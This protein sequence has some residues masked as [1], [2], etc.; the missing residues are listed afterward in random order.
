MWSN[1]ELPLVEAVM[2]RVNVS[3]GA[4]AVLKCR[5]KSSPTDTDIDIH[6][7]HNA[8]P[9][10]AADQSVIRQSMYTTFSYHFLLFLYCSVLTLLVGRQ[11]GHPAC[12]KLSCGVLV[13]L[14]VSSE[15]Q[16]CIWPSGP[17]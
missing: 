3:E 8:S 7:F 14:S 9:I 13:W 10:S 17:S 1:A 11:E 6:W 5:I 16:T 12:K 2:D 15:V 4:R